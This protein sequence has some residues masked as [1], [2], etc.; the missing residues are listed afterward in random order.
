MSDIN[1][2]F[3]D[4]LQYLIREKIVKD[5][6]DFANKCGISTSMLTEISK[7]RTQ[8]GA[9]VI[10][11][12]VLHF[13]LN[14]NWLLT[15]QGDMLISNDNTTPTTTP[16]IPE[17]VSTYIKEG[18]REGIPLLPFDAFGGAGSELLDGY[19]FDQ[20]EERYNIPLFRGIHIDF[21]IPVKGSSMYPKYNS[22]DVVACRLI[23]EI[24]YIQWNKVYVIDS[25]SQGTIIKRLKRSK[26]DN[27]VM[28]VSDNA[29]YEPFEI[30]LSDIRSF[31]L[32]VGVVRLE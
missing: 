23:N 32:V 30:P 31:A 4:F 28:C 19:N 10:H 27:H 29:S 3:L 13:N 15:S 21:M 12:S 16:V 20:T 6:A 26:S 14:A 25:I 11:N 9:K 22:G 18:Q 5:N 17:Q 8:V 2:R 7:G 24:L 1:I